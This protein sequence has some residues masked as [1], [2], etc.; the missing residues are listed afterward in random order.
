MRRR[1][2]TTTLVVAF[3]AVMTF[4][5]PLAVVVRGTAVTNELGELERAATRAERDVS[6]TS[7]RDG[8]DIVLHSAGRDIHLAVYDPQGRRVAGDGPVQ[9]ER[10][11]ISV[12]TGKVAEVRGA[13]LAVAVPVD[14]NEQIIGSVRAGSS[15]TEVF[16]RV[17]RAWLFIAL[18]ALAAI[19]LAALIAWLLA[20]R[21]SAPLR[22]LAATARVIG[23]GDFTAHEPPCGVAEIDTVA[24]ALATTAERLGAA[25]QRERAFSADVS[26]QL[27]TPITALKVTL[28]SAELTHR[29]DES[30]LREALAQAD[31][32]DHTVEELLALA[33]DTHTERGP[34]AVQSLVDE[35]DARE[36]RRLVA[37]GRDLAVSVAPHLPEVHASTA[38][39][40][41]ILTVLLDNA[42]EHG[43]GQVRVT[44]RELGE[45]LAI[46]VADD[47]TSMS[48][49]TQLVFARRSGDDPRRGI[50]LALAR[51][52]AE[53]EG[54]RLLLNATP[55]T[56]FSLVFAGHA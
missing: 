4:A 15:Q 33:R 19:G 10:P 24:A 32:L 55:T 9:L 37:A 36:R 14:A 43:T 56:V 41:Q 13:H 28:E 17:R 5:I 52:L 42:V 31:R 30:V 50:G 38:A 22:R 40:R 16:R 47:G 23:D 2:L 25:L 46:D 20:G 1:L 26:H 53:A 51:S 3:V 49:D 44:V 29:L 35:L 54:G 27:R 8:A 21:L 39:V 48:G 18:L 34:L 45:G 11:L 12:R 7:L 6:T